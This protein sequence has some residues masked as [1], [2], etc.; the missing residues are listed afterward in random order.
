MVWD[1]GGRD[2][3]RPLWR[4]YYH[5]VQAL[6]WVIDSNDRERIDDEQGQDNSAKEELHR[7]LAEDELSDIKLL[8]F[9][10]KQDLPNAMPIDEIH[11]RLAMKWFKIDWFIQSSC[12]ITG[13]GLYEGLDWLS[14]V[15]SKNKN[16]YQL[17]ST[18]EGTTWISKENWELIRINRNKS[19]LFVSGWV[20]NIDAK[21][22]LNIS[23]NLTRL[24]HDFYHDKAIEYDKSYAFYG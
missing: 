7:M 13:D 15:L 14:A 5:D 20:R 24:I 16:T 12:A 11:D 1:V 9:A 19:I 8:I 10:N 21:Y 18:G 6:I 2:K 4:H 23:A 3:I 17:P 22:K